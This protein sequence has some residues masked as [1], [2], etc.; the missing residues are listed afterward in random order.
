MSIL[1]GGGR[2]YGFEIDLIIP[3]SSYLLLLPL[4]PPPSSLFHISES[5]NSPLTIST[6]RPRAPRKRPNQSYTEAAALLST[7]YP[8][9]FSFKSLHKLSKHYKPP[10]FPVLNECG[11]LIENPSP[12]PQLPIHFGSKRASP[13]SEKSCTEYQGQGSPECSDYDVESILDEEVEEGIDSIMGNLSMENCEPQSSAHEF[14][15]E[16]GFGF[17]RENIRQ[18]IRGCHA[19]DWWRPMAAVPVGDIIPKLK[20]LPAA[21]KKKTKKKK[22][23]KKKIEDIRDEAEAWSDRDFPISTESG[24]AESSADVLARLAD[25][26]LLP[27]NEGGVR[28][29]S[30][31]RY[32][33]KRRNRLFSKKIRYQVRKMNADHRPRMKGRF[34][35]RPDLLQEAIEEESQ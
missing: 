28:E 26:D 23:K 5:S 33:E 15:N 34:V 9:L 19:G 24:A 22:K 13:S 18:A 4:C 25:I 20:A 6:K 11:F 2:T 31:Q 3:S 1:A 10:P 12:I 21:E 30:V 7:I 17:W 32:K 16:L 27:E 29:A 35:K 14:R 8:N